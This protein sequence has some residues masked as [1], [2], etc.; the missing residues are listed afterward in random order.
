MIGDFQRRETSRL[1][2]GSEKGNFPSVPR[3]PPGS[4]PVPPRFL[5]CCCLLRKDSRLQDQANKYDQDSFWVIHRN[6]LNCLILSPGF[7]QQ[8]DYVAI[9]AVFGRL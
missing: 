8:F 9:A 2:P 5:A 6:L 4:S 7:L 3:F 1:S